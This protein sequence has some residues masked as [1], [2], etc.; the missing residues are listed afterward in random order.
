MYLPYI[1]WRTLYFSPTVQTF[2]YCLLTVNIWRTV[3]PQKSENVW[4]HCS[5]STENATPL[6]S[7]H[8]EK[9]T[10]SSSTSPLASYK[11]VHLP[12]VLSL[13]LNFTFICFFMM[14]RLKQKELKCTPRIK[15]NHN[16]KMSTIFSLYFTLV[17][18]YINGCRVNGS[19]NSKPA[20]LY[21]PPPPQAFVTH[22]SF[23][24]YSYLEKGWRK[25]CTWQS[26]KALWMV[27]SSLCF[28][29]MW[30]N[31]HERPWKCVCKC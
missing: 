1:E 2:W 17:L 29:E 13:A 5:N 16:I 25:K 10:P 14:I 30:K 7:I 28:K 6:W 20:H 19:V 12:P 11:E 4:F 22:L 27:F 18:W 24:I 31:W 9:V 3:L 23:Y 15:L 26:R 8:C 21:P